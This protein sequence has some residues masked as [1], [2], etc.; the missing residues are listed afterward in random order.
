VPRPRLKLLEAEAVKVIHESALKL[1]EEVGVWIDN[2]EALALL[3]EAGAEVRGRVAAIPPSLVEEAV[4]K[5][6][7]SF[8]LYDTRGRPY[9]VI[10]EGVTH[11]N[12]GSAA[13]WI[14]DYGSAK[15]RRPTLED[16]E[17]VARL[18]DSLPNIK[19]QS[20][21]IVPW[22]VPEEL[23]DR[24][25]LYVVLKLSSKPV[26]T[27]AFTVEGARE[28][29]EMLRIVVGD[30]AEKPCAI[31]D[32]CPSPPL[33]WSRITSQNLLDCARSG[34][35]VEI[36]PLPQLGATA[37]VTLAGALVQHH[38]EALSGVVL[39]QLARPGAPVIYGG[40]PCEFDMFRATANIASPETM[41][42]Y[43]GYVEL[44]RE[45]GIPTHGYL[46]LSDSKLVD[47][48]AG[49]EA[50]MG[51]LV[52]ALAG[53]DVASGPGMLEFENVFS[54][55]KLVLDDEACGY[56]LRLAEGFEVDEER[57][58]LRVFREVRWSAGFLRHLHTVRH[59]REEHYVPRIFD[60]SPRAQSRATAL[61]IAHTEVERLLK[62]HE[63]EP[64]SSDVERRLDEAARGM[65]E[66][67]GLKLPKL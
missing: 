62:E 63:P 56:A 24:I 31:F 13:T 25:R 14:F 36:V 49:V 33:K 20:T 29:L 21:A 55:E 34:V 54:L 52:A 38:A 61:E 2:E 12:P 53:V 18:A 41:L 37:P 16:V 50:C 1:L 64:L 40:S 67:R 22:D 46:A 51:A 26:V 45:L 57:L 30:P 48:Q 60:R 8:T 59:F 39:A 9:A 32:V 35:P 7:R 5:V 19:L 10:G 47:Y 3:R 6:P 66:E 15:P 44:A 28:M 4:R 42:L 17:R 43:I 11:F 65:F 58:A 27:G 23:R